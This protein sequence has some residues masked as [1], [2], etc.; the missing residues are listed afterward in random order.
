MTSSYFGVKVTF[1]GKF[2]HLNDP[3]TGV[4]TTPHPNSRGKLHL[5]NYEHN[6]CTCSNQHIV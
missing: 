6:K 2:P 5:L 4:M 1:A 3:V